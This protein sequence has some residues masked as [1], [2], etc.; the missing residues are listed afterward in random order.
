LTVMDNAA[1]RRLYWVNF[2]PVVNHA[3][4]VADAKIYIAD[5]QGHIA[6]LAPAR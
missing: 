5:A 6:C 4:N 3:S 2:S 1:G